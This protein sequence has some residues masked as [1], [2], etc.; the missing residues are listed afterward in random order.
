M[1]NMY[2]ASKYKVI[3]QQALHH[4]RPKFLLFLGLVPSK[5]SSVRVKIAIDLYFLTL[6]AFNQL[7]LPTSQIEIF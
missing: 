1:S 4:Y 3:F 5:F 7:E 6:L 2:Q